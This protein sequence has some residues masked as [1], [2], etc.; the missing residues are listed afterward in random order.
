MLSCAE[1]QV[2]KGQTLAFIEQLGT[3]WPVESPQASRGQGQREGEEGEL[4]AG[5][6]WG[7]RIEGGEGLRPV[8]GL[9]MG[10]CTGKGCEADVEEG[11]QSC[12][13]LHHP[14]G[15]IPY[16]MRSAFL[17]PPRPHCLC[18]LPL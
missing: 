17:C 3:H 4:G 8:L 1:V 5:W 16:L 15:P 14:L 9:P 12:L 10:V 13:P 7:W 11:R 18:A 2:K 6:G